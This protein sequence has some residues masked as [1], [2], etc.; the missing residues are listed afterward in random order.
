M[1]VT[2]DTKMPSIHNPETI[3]FAEDNSDVRRILKSILEDNGYKVIE[4]VNGTDAVRLFLENED[5]I[6]IVL[7]DIIM[8]GKGGGEVYEEIKKV[9]PMT[10][11]LFI[12]GYTGDGLLKNKIAEEG[13]NYISKP[14]EPDE[15]LIK[16]RDVLD[17]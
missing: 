16:I 5:E 13:L 12:S 8:P 1:P 3:L 9:N 14:V 7:L 6:Q 4:A 2:V 10:K 15:L 11:I 17:K